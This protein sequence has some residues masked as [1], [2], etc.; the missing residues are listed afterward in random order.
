MVACGEDFSLAL[1]RSGNVYSTGAGNFGIHGC[2][3]SVE[4]GEDLKDRWAF[5]QIGAGDSGFFAN[6]GKSSI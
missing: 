4:N 6:I 3:D 5:S 1:S 2:G